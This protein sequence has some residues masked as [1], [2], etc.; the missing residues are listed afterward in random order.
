MPDEPRFE[1]ELD[2][3]RA[4]VSRLNSA[5]VPLEETIK[6]FEEGVKLAESCRKRLEDARVKIEELS[7][8][9]E[10]PSKKDRK[11]YRADASIRGE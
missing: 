1:D 2:K 11:I 5:D 9:L 3:L 6:L 8:A 10:P 7:K 4:I